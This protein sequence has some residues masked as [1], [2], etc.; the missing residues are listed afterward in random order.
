MPRHPAGDLHGAF[1][2]RRDV[3][4]RDRLEVQALNARGG[5]DGGDVGKVV[6]R[7]AAEGLKDANALG[8]EV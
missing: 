4:E 7:L 8:G 6:V 3:G 2:E 1:D 5:K